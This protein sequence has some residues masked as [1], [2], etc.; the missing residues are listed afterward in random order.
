LGTV[1]I[2]MSFMLKTIMKQS[3][4]SRKQYLN[5]SKNYLVE[6]RSNFQYSEGYI[7]CRQSTWSSFLLQELITK[8]WLFSFISYFKK[9]IIFHTKTE[10]F[11][12]RWPHTSHQAH[13]FAQLAVAKGKAIPV[14]GREGP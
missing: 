4:V 1:E 6:L 3:C 14:T 12:S 5:L 10:K 11:H 2:R 7:L 8:N 9:V 13:S